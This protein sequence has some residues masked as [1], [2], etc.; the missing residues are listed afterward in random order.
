MYSLNFIFRWEKLGLLCVKV[1][2]IILWMIVKRKLKIDVLCL[3]LDF[4]GMSK[5]NISCR[6]V[7]ERLLIDLE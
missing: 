6:K 1:V 7:V 3:I 5:R 4:K 2:N